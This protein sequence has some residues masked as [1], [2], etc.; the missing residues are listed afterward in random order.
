MVLEHADYRA[1]LKGVVAQRKRNNPAYSLRAFARQIGIGQSALSQILAGRKNLSLERAT[2]IATKLGLAA[3]ETEYFLVLIQLETA[4]NVDL[5]K[6]L[7]ARAR[8]LNPRHETRDLS[9]DLFSVIADW[10]HFAIKNMTGLEGIEFAPAKIAKRLG[11]SKIEAEAAIERLL[12][13]ELIEADPAR[14]GKFRRVESFTLT[15]SATPN[16]ALRRFHRQMLQKA[17]EA[18]E[19]QTPRERFTGSETFAI[20]EEHLPKAFALADEFLRKIAALSDESQHPT[21]VYHAGVQFFNLTKER[22]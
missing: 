16:E 18:L 6:S 1:F 11:I 3:V 2:Q 4:K 13:L 7:L 20:S 17:S 9:V 22:G 10:Y 14:A 21:Q 12:R 15:R 8:S 5:K 19:T